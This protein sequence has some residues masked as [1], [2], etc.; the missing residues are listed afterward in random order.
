[1]EESVQRIEELEADLVSANQEVENFRATLDS[2]KQELD[3]LRFENAR[4]Q[5]RISEGM[6]G[7]LLFSGA[8]EI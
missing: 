3:N 2:V 4:G 1:M 5:V 8:M 7:V 6:A